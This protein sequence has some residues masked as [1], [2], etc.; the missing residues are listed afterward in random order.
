MKPK[1]WYVLM[2]IIV[3]LCLCMITLVGCGDAGEPKEIKVNGRTCVSTD[4][5]LECDFTNDR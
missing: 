4:S 2:A 3:V 1:E 5:D